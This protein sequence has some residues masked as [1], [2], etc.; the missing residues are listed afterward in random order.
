[1][2][3]EDRDASPAQLMFGRQTRTLLPASPQLLIS[4]APSPQEAQEA[5]RRTKDK[6]EHYYNRGARPLQPLNIGDTIRVRTDRG[7][8]PK[9]SVQGTAGTPNS[10][11]V[12]LESGVS[13]RR[14]RR[15][16]RK[17]AEPCHPRQDVAESETLSPQSP[18]VAPGTPPR[19]RPPQASVSS[20]TAT[21]GDAPPASPDGTA[22]PGPSHTARYQPPR[23]VTRRARQRLPAPAREVVTRSGRT[24]KRPAYLCDYE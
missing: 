9:G 18:P 1:M 3:L 10:F 22:P 15:H 16:L 21:A 19:Q 24:S 20:T 14:N 2:P 4:S 5:L 7:A 17:T 23:A 11:R 6:Q 8:W 13:I 12:A